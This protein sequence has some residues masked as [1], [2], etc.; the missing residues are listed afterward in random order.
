MKT[1]KI[2][3]PTVLLAAFAVMFTLH[4]LF[5]LA[6]IVTGDWRLL[7]ILPLAIALTVDIL[8]DKTF[9][10]AKTT[11]KP[12]EES[13]TL[14]TNGFYAYSRNPMYLGFVLMLAGSAIILGTLLPWLVVI[15]FAS[16]MDRIYIR[17]EERMLAQTFGAEWQTYKK[18]TRRWL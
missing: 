14:V 8:T 12:F 15:V 17:V 13:S 16:L 4:F 10:Q 9:Q 5:P 1:K 11:I 2:L 6:E 3:P 18:K 7:G